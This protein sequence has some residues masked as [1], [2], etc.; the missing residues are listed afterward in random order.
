MEHETKDVVS[1]KS[2]D[3]GP[4][5]PSTGLGPTPDHWVEPAEKLLPAQREVVVPGSRCKVCEERIETPGWVPADGA[6]VCPNCDQKGCTRRSCR[7]CSQC[8]ELMCLSNSCS[9]FCD[10][11]GW[12]ICMA[13]A[14]A[15]DTTCEHGLLRLCT[16]CWHAA[17]RAE[18]KKLEQP[19]AAVALPL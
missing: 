9:T 19:A 6:S 7:L 1:I 2:D 8:G 16:Y 11:C 15:H 12:W 3:D 4:H 10:D 18:A 17:S 14:C 13:P 5:H